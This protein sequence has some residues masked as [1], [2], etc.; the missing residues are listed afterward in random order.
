MPQDR[1]STIRKERERGLILEI[2]VAFDLD[3]VPFAELRM[4]LVRMQHI[5]ISPDGLQ[6]Q[7]TYLKDRGYVETK[8]LYAGRAEVELTAVRATAKGVDL[9]DGRIEEDP[10]VALE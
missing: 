7:I 8:R 4:Q 9:L 1:V 2:L 3:W 5:P 6:F 10:G